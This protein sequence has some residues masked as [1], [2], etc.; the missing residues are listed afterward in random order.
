M[1]STMQ[2]AKFTGLTAILPATSEAR[3]Q[4]YRRAY[5]HNRHRIYALAF[6]MTD[7]E[8]V[9]EALMRHTFLRAF[10][11]GVEPSADTID[12][13]LITELRERMPLGAL[14]LDVGLCTEVQNVRSNTLRVELECAVVQLPATERLIFLLHD[15]ESYDHAPHRP[16]SGYL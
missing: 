3:R 1:A 5:E 2:Q 16:L 11:A 9:A 14:T 8:L 10:A 15:V 4:S 13:A 7:N 6:W 12:R